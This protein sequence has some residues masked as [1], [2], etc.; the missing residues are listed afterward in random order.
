MGKDDHQAVNLDT[1][2]THRT[3]DYGREVGECNACIAVY[4]VLILGA[5]IYGLFDPPKVSLRR[6]ERR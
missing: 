2:L 6:S 5:G 4:G 1:I 3:L